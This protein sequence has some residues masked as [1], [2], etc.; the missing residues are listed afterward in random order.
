MSLLPREIGDVTEDAYTRWR[1]K[2]GITGLPMK[3]DVSVV[4]KDLLGP[5]FSELLSIIFELP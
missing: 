2:E 1:N 4:L 5:L 3:N